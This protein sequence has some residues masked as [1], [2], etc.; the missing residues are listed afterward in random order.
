MMEA[1]KLTKGTEMNDCL[2]KIMI[3]ELPELEFEENGHIYKLDGAV[4]PS[5]TTIMNPLSQSL[6]GGIDETVLNAAAE[7]GTAVHNAIENYTLFGIDDIAPEYSGYLAAYKAW[8]N[9]FNPQPIST[10]RKVYH[11]V[12]RYAGTSD[13]IAMIE[14][15][16]ILVDYKTSA[17]VNKMLTGI[18]TEAYA[19]AYESHDYPID[20]KAILHLKK[21]GKYTWVYYDKNDSASWDVFG[22]LLTVFNHI[23][24]YKK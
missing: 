11:K 4:I 19:K 12:L 10:E 7:R 20:G 13:L 8:C 2:D 16:R 23:E 21:N 9:D 17:T 24:K 18:Q 3:P 22:A 6:Y 15:K 14:G 5:V 1:M